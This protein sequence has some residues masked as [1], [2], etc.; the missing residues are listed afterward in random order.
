MAEGVVIYPLSLQVAELALVIKIVIRKG[1]CDA[2]FIKQDVLTCI[3]IDFCALIVLGGLFVGAF[4]HGL[5]LVVGARPRRYLING[6]GL[7][8]P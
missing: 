7:D 6:L 5:L 1:P 4:A 2:I 8:R 3:F